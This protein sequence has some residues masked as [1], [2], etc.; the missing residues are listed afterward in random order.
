VNHRGE[1]RFVV[2]AFEALHI[3]VGY[4]DVG[5]G[6]ALGAAVVVAAAGVGHVAGVTVD[7]DR[8]TDDIALAVGRDERQQGTGGA[9][10]IPDAVE[11]V[12]VRLSGLP[13]GIL[14]VRSAGMSM[15]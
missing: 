6:S 10:G 5:V 15:M 14:A 7:I 4:N 8:A 2:D 1:G 11:V 13:I 3:R 9:K 12:V